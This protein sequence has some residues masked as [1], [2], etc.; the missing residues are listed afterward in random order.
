MDRSVSRR[1]TKWILYATHVVEPFFK[2]HHS[3]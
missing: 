1:E 2:I 3:K